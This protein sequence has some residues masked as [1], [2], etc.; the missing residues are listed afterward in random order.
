MMSWLDLKPWSIEARD[1]NDLEQTVA[2]WAAR[3][4]LANWIPSAIL[5]G[6]LLCSIVLFALS[7]MA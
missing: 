2:D 7:R 5:L 1:G 4:E 6:L 3:Q